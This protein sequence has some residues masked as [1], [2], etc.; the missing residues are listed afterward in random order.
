M[1]VDV[2]ALADAPEGTWFPVGAAAP[3]AP[4]AVDVSRGASAAETA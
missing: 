3:A 2:A 4:F 1:K